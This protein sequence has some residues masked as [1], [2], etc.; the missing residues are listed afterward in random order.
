MSIENKKFII[1]TKK[2]L[3]GTIDYSHAAILN[4]KIEKKTN[5]VLTED[6]L[7]NLSIQLLSAT[8][9]GK[10]IRLKQLAKEKESVVE[11]I[12]QELR[13][14]KKT[15]I[16]NK[17]KGNIRHFHRTG[18]ENFKIMA[19]MGKLISRSK[20]KKERPGHKMP[21]WS[22]SDDVMMTRDKFDS[23]GNMLEPGFY[24]KEV[25][26][27]SDSGLILIFKES[28]MN[29]DNYD[30]TGHYPTVSELSL[31]EY[32]EFLLVNTEKDKILVQQILLSN[33]LN[34]PVFLKSDW[35]R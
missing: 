3:D 4:K 13:M 20:L 21:S 19:E 23:D 28:I 9:I 22:S 17:E 14:Y 29:Q 11:E 5:S 27:A 12:L 34:I 26:G 8:E 32:C 35:K 25:V 10:K 2:N 18:I 1:G 6:E 33:N 30:V 24:E 31:E 16:K 15:Q 7:K